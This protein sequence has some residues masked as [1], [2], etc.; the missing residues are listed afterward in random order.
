MRRILVTG[1]AG[2]IGSALIR[3]LMI[4]TSATVLNIDKLTYAGNLSSLTSITSKQSNYIHRYQFL[5]ADIADTSTITKAIIDFKPDAIMNL[6]AESHVD[7]SINS[8]SDFIDTNIKGTFVLL[9]AALSYW[10]SLTKIQQQ[11]FRFH[12][13]STDEVYGSLGS[14]GLFNEQTPYDPR[15]PYSASKAASDHLVKAWFYTYGLPIVITNCTNNYGPYQFPEKLIPLVIL[16]ALYEK[17]LPIYGRGD[18]VRD[19]LYVDD[20]V[21]ALMLVVVSGQPGETYS[22]GGNQE[23]TNLQVVEAICAQLDDLQPRANCRPYNEL[24]SYVD[25]RLGHDKRYAIDA[26]K[27]KTHLNWQ[28]KESFESGLNKTLH[29]YLESAWWWKPLLSKQ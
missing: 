18:N 6:A 13:I 1:G 23:K 17:P 12:H 3:H 9:E 29:W 4:N 22:I 28:P 21:E 5:Q 27:I 20:H 24:I 7:R 10:S 16:N 15:S 2:F 8:P 11:S 14:E 25:D 19:W 26:T